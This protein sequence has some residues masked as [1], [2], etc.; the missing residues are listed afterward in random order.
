MRYKG[1]GLDNECIVCS[2]GEFNYRERVLC[3]V[4]ARWIV[5][6]SA[7]ACVGGGGGGVEVVFSCRRSL[8]YRSAAPKNLLSSRAFFFILKSS[9]LAV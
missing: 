5:N 1:L 2:F 8:I 4:A 9:S 6:V 3:A 7:C